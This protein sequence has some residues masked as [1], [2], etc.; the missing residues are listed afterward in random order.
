ML[1]LRNGTDGFLTMVDLAWLPRKV[2]AL[3]AL[4]IGLC[5]GSVPA[6]A[7]TVDF[8]LACDLDGSCGAGDFFVD[9]PEALDDLNFVAQA[10]TPF[11]DSL[12]AISGATVTFT[13]PDT[14][15]V[16]TQ[17]SGFAAPADAVTIYV[18]GR[19]LPD[20][21]VGVAGPGGPNG[22]FARGQGTIV[23]GAADDFAMWGGAI[24]FDT[25]S[26][27]D[28]DRN[29][30]FGSD[31]S[32]GVGKVDF[33]SVALHELG[34]LFGFGTAD[35]FENQVAG[36]EF[37]GAATAALYG[38]NVPVLFNSASSNHEHWAGGVASPPYD[39]QPTPSF[40]A[41]LISGRRTLLTPLDYAGLQDLGWEVPAQLL[42]LH[43]NTDDDDDVDGVDFLAWQRGFGTAS[44]ASAL[45]GDL[46]GQG[47][48]DSF[49]F[50]LWEQ[51]YGATS[52]LGGLVATEQIPEPAAWCLL[53]I[54]ALLLNRKR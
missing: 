31:A 53:A 44:G 2:C 21:Q 36:G 39:E 25:K 28:L 48:V 11:A 52:T 12:S 1:P 15:A 9:H 54:G 6:N 10:F 5:W 49:D 33:I 40:G 13:H 50:W 38:D 45:M 18:G 29:W 7:I 37:Q 26:F 24:A 46:N 51:N 3:L 41:S 35:S 43:G 16:G 32:P 20:N 17:L 42:G 30:Y 14:G 27:G 19:D 23:D 4:G 22:V 47:A 8:Q 34:H